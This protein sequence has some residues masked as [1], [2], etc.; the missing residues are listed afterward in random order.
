ML[1]QYI[2]YLLGCQPY[3]LFGL[4][5]YIF[6]LVYLLGLI[7]GAKITVD[8]PSWF[9]STVGSSSVPGV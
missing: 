7:R 4:L 5:G 9:S 2:Q 8:A 1:S 3:S 6:S